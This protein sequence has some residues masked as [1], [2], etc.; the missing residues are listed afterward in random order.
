ML[1]SWNTGFK[2]CVLLTIEEL[3]AV[4]PEI[5]QNSESISKSSIELVALYRKV[6]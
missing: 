4:Y 6:Q 3:T 1:P 5:E 2:S